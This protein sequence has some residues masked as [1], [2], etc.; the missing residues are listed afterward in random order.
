M[1]TY[2]YIIVGAGSA[3]C[4]VAARLSEDPNIRVLLLEAGLPPDDFWI[5]VP[6]GMAHLFLSKRFNWG[7]FTE[8][9]PA[10][11]NR[12]LYWPR[13]KTLGG[14]SAI[15]GMV[16]IRGNARDYDN[17]S[18]LGNAGW[19]WSDVLPFFKRSEHNTRGKTEQHGTGG[20]LWVSDP[21]LRHPSSRDFVESAVRVGIPANSD[22]NGPTQ[23]GTGFFQFTIRKGVRHSAHSAFLHSVRNRPNLTIET[24]AHTRRIVLKNGQ[25]TGI[26]FIQDGMV[27]VVDA[28]REV[29]LAAGALNSPQ[30]LM[31][32]GI[33]D[34]A[35]LH[36]HGIA[37][38]LHSPGVGKNLQDHMYAHCSV[39]STSHS[40]YNRNLNGLRKYIE[41]ARYLIT[42]K[43]YLG[44]GSS[45]ACAFVRSSP[46]IEYPDLQINFRPMTFNF[47][48]S[49]KVFVDNYPAISASVCHLRP[50]SRG[51]VAL[52]SADSTDA[53]V[54]IPNYLAEEADRKA[55]TAGLRRIRQIFASEPVAS[56]V[57]E[58]MVPGK[59]VQSD[60]E[61]L[62]F[63]RQFGNSAYHPVGTCK[64]GQDA[65][66]VV[67]E[68]LR[69]RGIE[70]LRVVDASIMPTIISG[71]TNAP[72]IMIGEK[73]AEMI[74]ADSIPRRSVS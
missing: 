4:A 22:F 26:E 16:Y 66:A 7:Y 23:E 18:H 35:E 59:A 49:G 20:E 27:R 1:N 40:S 67:D 54:L 69:V 31:L 56:R 12:K 61:F 24:G 34:A 52:R 64:M 10:F 3:G 6:A 29:I 32:S 8:P 70:R 68:R 45:Q 21:V 65:M 25:A 43:G 58:E 28:A 13:G 9:I 63:L 11:N 60:A 37:V 17:W 41:G 38:A 53:P 39:K 47:H 51:Q 73:G 42:R 57:I 44:L 46:E 36:Q 14:T 5:N 62:G 30:I 74:R 71:N 50:Q 2:D 72:S 19:S 33:G 15:N 48:P 55:M